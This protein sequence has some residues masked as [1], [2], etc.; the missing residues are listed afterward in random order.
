VST[1]IPADVDVPDKVLAGLTARQVVILAGTAL[2]VWGGWQASIGQV[3]GWLVALLAVPVAVGGV[4]LALVRRD[5]ITLDELARAALTYHA[6]PRRLRHP[7]RDRGEEVPRWLADRAHHTTRGAGE[8]EVFGVRVGHA[9][10]GPLSPGTLGLGAASVAAHRYGVMRVGVLDLGPDGAAVIAAAST[11]NL[12]LRTEEE[13]H[14]VVGCFARLLHAA[15]PM[16][17]IIRTQPVDL[18]PMLADITHA[19]HTLAHP[20]LRAAAAAHRDYL[21]DIAATQP[22]ARHVLLV[23]RESAPARATSTVGGGGA[24]VH[25][26][27]VARLLGRLDEA[28][29]ALAPAEITVTPLDAAAT[30]AVLAAAA[31]PDRPLTALSTHQRVGPPRNPDTYSCV[32]D[33]HRVPAATGWGWPS[34]PA[35]GADLVELAHRSG[36]T[37]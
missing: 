17:I 36:W 19:T 23:L 14:A 35:R 7:G 12:G 13:Q 2:I 15:G 18:S 37:R 4:A 34:E 1:P 27:V 33:G 5:G 20:A 25:P 16:Q 8:G 9:R 11:I 22:L 28:Q 29:R 30:A 3:P 31:D 24:V 10:P 6:G 32:A 21:A 26:S